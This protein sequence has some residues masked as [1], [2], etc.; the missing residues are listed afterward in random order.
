MNEPNGFIM[1]GYNSGTFP[2]G[3]CSNYVGNCTAGNSAT[4]PYIAAHHLILCHAAALK[5]YND[6]YQVFS[7]FFFK[8]IIL[9][10]YQKLLLL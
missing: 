5:L 3:R 9:E 8:K 10:Q 4:E 7:F 6:K 2:P 1:N